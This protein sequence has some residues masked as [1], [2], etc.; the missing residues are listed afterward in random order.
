MDAHACFQMVTRNVADLYLKV[1]PQSRVDYELSTPFQKNPKGMT[2]LHLVCNEGFQDAV[3]LFIDRKGSEKYI[4][5]LD[6]E[7]N[8]PIK[9]ACKQGYYYIVMIL[10]EKGATIDSFVYNSTQ[11]FLFDMKHTLFNMRSGMN[12][13]LNH[14]QRKILGTDI[15]YMQ[16]NY[17][18][19]ISAL[20]NSRTVM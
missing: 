11:T 10:M 17:N 6:Y 20:Q 15:Y 3:H 2:W 7:G 19:L 16:N 18:R 8:T 5:A 12:Y 9:L 4:N 1:M 13:N 14:H